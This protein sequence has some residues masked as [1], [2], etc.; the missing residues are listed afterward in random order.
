[1]RARNIALT[2]FMAVGKSVVG[3][4]LARRLGWRL[5]DVD[6]AIEEEQ[7]MK[8]QEIFEREGEAYFRK[9]EKRK[10]GEMLSE[11]NRVIATGGGAVLDDENLSLLKRQSLLVCLT[12]SPE[13]LLRRSGSGKERPLLQG[14]DKRRR[15]EELLS[16]RKER[17]AQAH[18]CIDTEARTVDQVVEE[19]IAAL[20][21][22][23]GKMK[24]AK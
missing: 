9:L 20:R 16:R 2:G 17:Y 21:N 24:S 19:I 5:V 15:I 14:D 11:E 4:K 1:M 7:G 18:L 3:R 8:V 23:K 6:R 10:L 13:T 12:A 22:A